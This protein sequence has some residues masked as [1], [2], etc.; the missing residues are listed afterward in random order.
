[1]SYTLKLRQWSTYEYDKTAP[2]LVLHATIFCEFYESFRSKIVLYFI[3]VTF[4]SFADKSCVR[5]RMI[6]LLLLIWLLFIISQQFE[7]I[8]NLCGWT[9][10]NDD[11]LMLRSTELSLCFFIYA[12]SNMLEWHLKCVTIKHQ[13]IFFR[14]FNVEKRHKAL[15]T[16]A[17]AR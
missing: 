17:T 12:S 3:T 1:M 7:T 4:S 8:T 14:N 11:N 9:K 6:L 13:L 16:K 2:Y 15:K 5:L 10:P